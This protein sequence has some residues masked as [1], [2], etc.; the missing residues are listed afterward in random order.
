MMRAERKQRHWSQG[1]YQ[2]PSGRTFLLLWPRYDEQIANIMWTHAEHIGSRHEDV[3]FISIDE[4][5]Y[6]GKP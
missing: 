3:P 2:L 4:A 5:V 6:V 1:R